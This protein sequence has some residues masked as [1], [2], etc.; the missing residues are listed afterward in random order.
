MSWRIA[1]EAM[2]LVP[3]LRFGRQPPVQ[4]AAPAGERVPTQT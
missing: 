4:P 1:T 3:R 2:W